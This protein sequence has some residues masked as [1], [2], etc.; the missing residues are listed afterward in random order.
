LIARLGKG[1]LN[2]QEG[3]SEIGRQLENTMTDSEIENEF[4]W[5]LYGVLSNWRLWL[6][7]DHLRAVHVGFDSSNTEISISLLTDR[8]PGLER[9]KLDPFSERNGNWPTADWRLSCVNHTAKH[10]F[11]DCQQLLSWMHETINAIDE[12]DEGDEFNERLQKVF[13]NVLTSDRI[14]QEL[15]RFRDRDEPLKV[16]VTWFFGESLDASLELGP[17]K[18]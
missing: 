12:D 3:Y 5:G 16:R 1:L 18:K 17:P 8:E 7:G 15:A 2:P 9:Q 13:F 6:G 10:G 11:P 14:K 4:Y